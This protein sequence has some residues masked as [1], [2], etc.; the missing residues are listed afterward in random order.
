MLSV[1]WSSLPPKSISSHLLD[2][3][4]IIQIELREFGLQDAKPPIDHHLVMIQGAHLLTA[5][6]QSGRL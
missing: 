3:L 1:L 5:L 4:L 2:S 6:E